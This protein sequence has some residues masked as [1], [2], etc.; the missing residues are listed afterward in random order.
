MN[1]RS[2]RT[3]ELTSSYCP[4][5][6]HISTAR[7]QLESSDPVPIPPRVFHA[8]AGLLRGPT[9]RPRRRTDTPRT[10][11]ASRRARATSALSRPRRLAI[12]IAAG[13]R[14]TT[15][16][17]VRT[18][19]INGPLRRAS[20]A[21]LVFACVIS[22]RVGRPRRIGYLEGVSPN[23]ALTAL[24][25]RKRAGDIEQ[26]HHRSAPPPGRHQDPPSGVEHTSSS[27]HHR[28]DGGD[29][30]RQSARAHR[31][32]RTMVRRRHSEVERK[33]S[34]RPLV[35]SSPNLAVPTI[36]HLQTKVAQGGA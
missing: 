6:V 5:E 15:I 12:V 17:V 26:P 18:S 35:T 11:T 25:F 33:I 14:A 10:T 7:R 32:R 4:C 29:A 27:R 16:S 2:K 13:P 24:E 31:R 30:G 36:P 19:R 20:A 28:E 23:A 8:A 34:R 9:G 1:G 3:Y 21:S 22:R